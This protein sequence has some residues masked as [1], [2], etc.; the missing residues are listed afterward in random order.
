[1]SARVRIFGALAALEASDRE[2]LL[3]RSLSVAGDAVSDAVRMLVE[4]VRREGDQ[5]LRRQAARF[6]GVALESLEVPRSAW[7]EALERQPRA[8]VDALE[9]AARN[10]RAVH[11]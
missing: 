1:M 3:S 7:V 2:L 6:D 11:A 5:A 9:R 4:E 10:I 8:L